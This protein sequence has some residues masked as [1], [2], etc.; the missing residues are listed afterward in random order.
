MGGM[1]PKTGKNQTSTEGR[2]RVDGVE[3]VVVIIGE[4]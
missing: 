4:S 3:K 2:I 1:R